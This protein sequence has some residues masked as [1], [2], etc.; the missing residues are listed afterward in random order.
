MAEDLTT[1]D[2][3]S[4]RP[5]TAPEAKEFERSVDELL[6][7][8]DPG[9]TRTLNAKRIGLRSG[10]EREI[11]VLIEGTLAGSPISISVECKSYNRTVGIGMIDEF[12][13]KLLDLEV[14]KGVF[15]SFGRLS[16]GAHARAKGAFHPQ[17]EVREWSVVEPAFPAWSEDLEEFHIELNCPNENC[18]M[19]EVS[20]TDSFEQERGG[21]PVVTGTC[22]SCGTAAYECRDCGEVDTYFHGS[23]SCYTCGAEYEVTFD[24]GGD[25]VEDFQL[26]KAGEA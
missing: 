17:I 19:G 12:V 24:H 14:E 23:L 1:D 20:W 11:D 25:G 10:R 22:D 2:D 15:Y 5:L 21:D 16:A 9:A 18:L 7:R 3:N 4:K 13:G 6:S 26:V 8:L